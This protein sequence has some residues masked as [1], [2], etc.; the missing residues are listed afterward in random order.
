MFKHEVILDSRS[1]TVCNNAI[2]TDRMGHLGDAKV[3]N[4]TIFFKC[5][6]FGHQ[7]MYE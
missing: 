4:I 6:E 3:R 5:S 7:R 1:T 2:L